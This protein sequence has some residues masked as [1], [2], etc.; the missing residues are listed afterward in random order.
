MKIIVCITGASGVIYGF[1]TI[2]SLLRGGAEISLVISKNGFKVINEELGFS[3]NEPDFIEKIIPAFSSD[4]LKLYHQ[5][6][7]TAPFAS[8]SANFDA[9]LFAPCSMATLGKIASSI[10][11]NLI[12]R[13]ADVFLKEKRKLILLFRE[14]PLH[15]IH[16]DNMRKLAMAGAIIMPASPAFYTRPNNL[17]Q[18]IDFV[19]GRILDQLQIS[20]HN[21]YPPYQ[22]G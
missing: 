10:G 18:M 3:G 4:S 19:V 20:D 2:E 17:D 15:L 1:R 5:D 8:G 9:C 14:M 21:L 6:D 7:L 13:T 22:N 12:T 11:D 16:I